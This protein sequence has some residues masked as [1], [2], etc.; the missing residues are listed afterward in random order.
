MSR[1]FFTDRDLGKRFPEILRIAGLS[2]ERR[3]R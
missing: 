1:V 2:V 3:C